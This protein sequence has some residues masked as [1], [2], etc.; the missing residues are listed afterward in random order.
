MLNFSG[1]NIAW[2]WSSTVPVCRYCAAFPGNVSIGKEHCDT[3]IWS[4]VQFVVKFLRL[5]KRLTT[6]QDRGYG[7]A[8]SASPWHGGGREFESP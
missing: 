4:S 2:K 8:G 5:C 1:L 3:P 6:K 7:A